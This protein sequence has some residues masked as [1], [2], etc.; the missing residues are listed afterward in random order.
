MH[1][2][3][4]II[5]FVLLILPSS[6]NLCSQPSPKTPKTLYPSHRPYHP[7]IVGTPPPI[8]QAHPLA[9]I[10]FSK[11]SHVVSISSNPFISILPN[12][13][14]LSSQLFQILIPFHL[15]SSENQFPFSPILPNTNSL[16]FQFFQIKFPCIIRS[17]SFLRGCGLH[18]DLVDLV[19]GGID[20]SYVDIT[21]IRRP[22]LISPAHIQCLRWRKTAWAACTPC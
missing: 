10:L 5:L 3:C 12:T 18:P 1:Q 11:S 16:A 19:G 13:N 14:S 15:N 9:S 22:G 8:N 2:S 17:S 20:L 21:S 6:S 4:L 7:L